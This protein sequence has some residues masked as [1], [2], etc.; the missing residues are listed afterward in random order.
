MLLS[1]YLKEKQ[2]IKEIA[3]QEG[4]TVEEVR[5]EMEIS[6]DEAYRN[7]GTDKS[8]EFQKL[9]GNIKPTPEEFINKVS[10]QLIK[11]KL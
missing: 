3:R 6:I 7:N 10:K 4:I 1:K 11:G 9:F 5:K 8:K 2:I